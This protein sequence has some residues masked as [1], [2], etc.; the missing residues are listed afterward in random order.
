MLICQPG[1]SYQNVLM[2]YLNYQTYGFDLNLHYSEKLYATLHFSLASLQTNLC[3]LLPAL[4]SHTSFLFEEA[5]V[6]R[7]PSPT[8]CPLGSVD[9]IDN[10]L[11]LKILPSLVSVTL[12]SPG[13]RKLPGTNILHGLLPGPKFPQG[14]VLSPYLFSL[15]NSLPEW[16]HSLTHTGRS[17]S[18]SPDP[19]SPWTSDSVFQFS[20][21]L[22]TLQSLR[23]QSQCVQ[24]SPSHMTSSQICAV[25]FT[26]ANSLSPSPQSPKS[27]ALGYI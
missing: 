10:V 5:M 22:L 3:N 15:L 17:M 23:H 18:P 1:E 14:L 13:L 2:D 27:E 24:N 21:E 20:S 11:P 7:W 26:L 8:A 16:S 25:G 9:T 6:C 19:A 12:I 4:P